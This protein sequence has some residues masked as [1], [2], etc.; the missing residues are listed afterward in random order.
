MH[1]ASTRVQFYEGMDG[2]KQMLWN[3]ARAARGENLAILYDNMQHKTNLAF[4]ERWVRKCNEAG[5]QFRGIIGDEFIRTQQA[6]YASHSNERLARWQAR[7]VP[8]ELF[9]IRHSVVTYDDV[10]LHYHCQ[11]NRVLGIEI[12]DALIAQMQRQFFELLWQQST[13]VDDLRG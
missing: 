11:D 8:D 7:H 3:Q 4:F 2:V 12:H 10:V 6:W 5:I 9:P 13:A 1:A